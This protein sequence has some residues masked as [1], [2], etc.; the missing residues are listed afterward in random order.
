MK[1][2]KW[3]NKPTGNAHNNYSEEKVME[4]QSKYPK[5]MQQKQKVFVKPYKY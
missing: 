5:E 2:Q 1:I 3:L 4:K